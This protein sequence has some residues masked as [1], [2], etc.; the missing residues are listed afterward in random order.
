MLQMPFSIVL[1]IPCLNS[2]Q[3]I[4]TQKAVVGGSHNRPSSF[5]TIS[6]MKQFSLFISCYKSKILIMYVKEKTGL[7]CK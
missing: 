4:F 5:K 2:I 1:T 3:L 7:T 6:P